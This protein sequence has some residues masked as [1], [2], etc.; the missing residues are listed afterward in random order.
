LVI[1]SEFPEEAKVIRAARLRNDSMPGKVAE[2]IIRLM[3]GLDMPNIACLGASYKGNIGDTR[4]SPALEIYQK[5]QGEQGESL[6]VVLHDN[7]ID[8]SRF[9]TQSLDSAV[10]DASL[11][12]VLVDHEEYK[13][14][15]PYTIGKMVHRKCILDTRN[16]LN[17]QEWRSSGFE[18]H[19]L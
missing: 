7:H 12:V 1:A 6:Q 17:H 16:L 11:F 2:E 3:K 19:V 5:L 9:S 13:S 10:K 8:N 4:N 15:D 18:V 14:I